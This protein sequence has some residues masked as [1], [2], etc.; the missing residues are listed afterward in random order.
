MD[1][2]IITASS[3]VKTYGRGRKRI[4]AV[5]GID[6]RTRRGEIFGL[7]G[8]DGAGKT[9]TIQMLC[10][11]L[12]PSAGQAIVAGVDVVRHAERL[13]GKIGYMSEG[14]TLYGTLTVAENID[15]F[16]QLY[17]V[18][19]DEIAP[20]KEKLLR[21]AR[22][23]EARDR[24]A[25]NLSGGMKKKLA[26]AC[27]LIHRPEVLFLDEPTTGVDPASRQD[28]W[29]IL[30]EFLAEGITIFVSTP[31]MD[32]A[33]RCH[34]VALI[35]EGQIVAQDTPMGLKRL[36]PGVSVDLTAHPQPEAVIRLRQMIDIVKQ[37]QVFGE[38]LHVLLSNGHNTP[39]ELAG[40]LEAEGVSVTGIQTTAPSLEDVFIAAIEDMRQTGDDQPGA[41][42]SELPSGATHTHL[43]T[44]AVSVE[45]LTRRFGTFT[46][47]DGISLD[48][49]SG[50]IFGFLGPNGSG[51][52]TTIRML[53]G[54]LPPTTGKATVA[55]F[56]IT[57]QR[58]DMKTRI[59]YMSQKFSLYN[60]LTIAENIQFFGNLY[61]LSGQHLQERRQ[62]VLEMAGL[63]GKDH[64]KVHNLSGG[65]KQRLALGCAILHEPEILFLDEPTSGVD[66]LARREFWDLIFSLSSQGVTV[67]VTTHYM[68]EAE[69]CH[70]LGL[71]YRGR[72]I[73]RGSP[74]ELRRNMK[75]GQLL[76]IPVRDPLAALPFVA[77]LPENIQTSIFG[78]RLHALVWDADTGQQ[79]ITQALHPH[80]LMTGPIQ[81]VPISLEDLF[82]LFIEMEE[83]G[84]LVR[85][86]T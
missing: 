85:S 29:T 25:E 32:E 72:I 47:V 68:D 16:A 38:R 10:G 69:H 6:L 13:G 67:F 55:G 70:Q 71:L 74:S 73:A 58:S 77:A 33:E 23:E 83:E 46:A 11:I 14:F 44:L 21:F 52:T 75:L 80:N 51:K 30:Y 59:G 4:E 39:E 9:T 86:T 45:N 84:R 27:T 49:R 12:T 57:R 62:W 60:D 76:E 35:R 24:R 63:V 82:M 7:V 50:E 40:V 56:D 81:Q 43:E 36:V 8:P 34:H 65:W 2:P 18:P 54:L 64:L 79:A 31:Y 20:R 42:S 15:F 3:L 41:I 1:T 37:V 22:L 5:K 48:V 19:S 66:P 78:D 61:G 53:C 26:L 28:F 17:K